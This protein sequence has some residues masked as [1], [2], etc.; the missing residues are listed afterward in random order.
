AQ[1]FSK[2]PSQVPESAQQKRVVRDPCFGRA[3]LLDF[4]ATG[5]SAPH[6]LWKY[7]WKSCGRKRGK[8]ATSAG[9]SASYQAHRSLMHKKSPGWRHTRAPKQIPGDRSMRLSSDINPATPL[10]N[11]I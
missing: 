6:I 9:G 1:K 7:R 8:S 4:V 2:N 11:P 3:S 10:I 5:S